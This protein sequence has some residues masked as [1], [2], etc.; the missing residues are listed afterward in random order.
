MSYSFEMLPD[1]PILIGTLHDSFSLKHDSGSYF[2]EANSIL[3]SADQSI[4]HI[5]DVRAL[6]VNVFQDF[7]TA[8]NQSARGNEAML[9]HPNINTTVVVSTDK[10][11]QLTVKGLN[12]NIFGNLSLPVFDTLEE[13]LTYIRSLIEHEFKHE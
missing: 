2:S 13:A 3:D 5:I 11:I 7:L 12:S 6:Q 8:V 4:C 1:E 9:R 10:L